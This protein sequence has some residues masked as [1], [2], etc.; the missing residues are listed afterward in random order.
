MT[1]NV[2]INGFGRIGRIVTFHT[3]YLCWC[4]DRFS[5][6]LWT[7]RMFKSRQSMILS[8]IL[9]TCTL[10]QENGT[11]NVRVY[12]FKYD[13]THGRFKGDVHSENG[14]LVINGQVIDVYGERDPGNIPWAKSGAEVRSHFSQINFLV[15]R[16]VDRCFYDHREGIRSLQGRSKESGHLCPLCRCTHVCLRCQ[17]RHLQTRI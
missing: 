14:K 15:H 10:L 11:S 13:S 9:N 17:S 2:G 5:E 3:L 4:H 8:S 7:T 16:R 1:V 12:M 6:M